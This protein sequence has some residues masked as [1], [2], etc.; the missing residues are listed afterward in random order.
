MSIVFKSNKAAKKYLSSSLDN[1]L[2]KGGKRV[3]MNF[4]TQIYNLD[5]VAKK[6]NDLISFVRGTNAGYLDKNGNYLVA[7]VNKER[8]HT[9][10]DI[11]T[12]LLVEPSA[13]NLLNNPSVPANQTINTN[14]SYATWFVLQ[15]F[16]SGT[17]TV[18]IK[19]SSG[20]VI[21]SGVS[22]QIAPFFYRPATSISG[23]TVT[24]TPNNITHFQAFENFLPRIKQTK[25]PTGST[26]GDIVMFNKSTLSQLL[27]KN[28][29]LSIVVKKSEFKSYVDETLSVTQTG[30]ILQIIQESN[31]NGLF[32]ARQ[33]GAA[34][35]KSMLRMSLSVESSLRNTR[36]SKNEETFI[37]IFDASTV[38]MYTQGESI[39]LPI[40]EA[41]VLTRL[42]IGGGITWSQNFEHLLKEIYIYDRKLTDLELNNL[43]SG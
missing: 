2:P 43:I 10:S 27:S 30:T 24:V 4:E 13:I 42:Y 36:V 1:K 8:I 41:L 14:L 29:S 7:G 9:S 39:E 35:D 20:V 19:N 6:F 16:G 23:V 32:V 3:S 21:A 34:T 26:S 25:M 40:T 18:E 22:T 5:G 33:R 15:V 28:N 11:G 17:C 31:A 12:G 37:L 38:K